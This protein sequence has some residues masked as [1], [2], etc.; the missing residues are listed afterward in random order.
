[1][2]NQ[3]PRQII[4]YLKFLENCKI[5]NKHK[6][7]YFEKHHII[8]KCLNG[9]DDKANLIKLTA[10]QHFIAHYMLTK[11]YPDN[12]KIHYALFAM[13][14]NAETNSRYLNSK[15]IAIARE[16][17]AKA[18]SIAKQGNTNWLG[19]KHKTSSKKAIGKANKTRKAKF[20]YYNSFSDAERHRR[21]EEAK[22]RWVIYRI[23]KAQRPEAIM[24]MIQALVHNKQMI[25]EVPNISLKLM[26]IWSDLYAKARAVAQATG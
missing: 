15:H 14:W 13:S 1:M 12:A 21:S 9:S 4:R 26:M 22:A 11:C 24:N 20:G 18:T 3:Q 8:P 10:R 19:K 25:V 16:A 6:T 2:G 17:Q 7:G 5:A 23:C